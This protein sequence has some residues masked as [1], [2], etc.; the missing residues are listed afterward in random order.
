M[1]GSRTLRDL[2]RWAE[3]APLGTLIPADS[4]AA[5]LSGV[6]DGDDRLADL[7]VE[8]TAQQLNRAPSTVRGWLIAGELRGYKLNHR[9][10]RVSRASVR[11]YLANQRNG[12]GRSPS[13]SNGKAADLSAWREAR[14]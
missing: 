8:E 3:N 7:T 12:S 13:R 5:M 1:S 10:W 2:Q 4:L 6:E 11:E 14:R 9:E